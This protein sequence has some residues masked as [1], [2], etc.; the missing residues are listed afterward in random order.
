[1]RIALVKEGFGHPQSLP[2]VDQLVREAADGCGAWAPRS[3]GLDPDAQAGPGD[4]AADRGRGRHGA[5]DA[6]QRLRLQLA[7]AL[8]HQPPGLAQRLADR[9]DELSD[10]LKN[11]M[12]LG[13]YMVTHYRGQ[14]Y[15]KA[16]NLVRRLRAAYDAVLKDHDLLLMPTLPLTAPPIPD[17][18]APIAEIL[19]RASRCCRTPPPSTAPTTPP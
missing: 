2:A 12:L 7:G 15:A 9:A 19:Q 14:Y 10:T 4:L 1:M 16:Q 8:R 11:T 3:R 5:D 13:H 6:R 17:E 18:D